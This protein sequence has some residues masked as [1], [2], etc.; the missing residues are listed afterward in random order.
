MGDLK[1]GMDKQHHTITIR[2]LSGPSFQ[3]NSIEKNM[4]APEFPFFQHV[5]KIGDNTTSQIRSH[6][7][8][9]SLILGIDKVTLCT[10]TWTEIPMTTQRFVWNSSEL[11]NS[12]SPW[13]RVRFS[14][15]ELRFSLLPYQLDPPSSPT[16]T[17]DLQY[18]IAHV[19]TVI[20]N[21]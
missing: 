13:I 4:A 18:F 8:D 12:H 10:T 14:P 1:S 5:N 6:N 17:L 16:T 20:D 7:I 9:I 2:G 15:A 21:F 3:P 19:S 11:F